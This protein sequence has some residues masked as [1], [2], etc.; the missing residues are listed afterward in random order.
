M[1]YERRFRVRAPV[2][3]VLAFHEDTAGLRALTPMPMT[4]HSAPGRLEAGEEVTFTV[5]AG[6]VPLRWEG[7]VENFSE[8]GFDDILLSGPF[9][10]WRHHHRFHRIRDNLTEVH[11]LV[12]AELPD[13]LS[14]AYPVAAL[15]W[16]SL[17]LLFSY[18]TWQTRQL[19]ES[20]WTGW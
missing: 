13:L 11:D 5:W 8:D 16:I 12:Q 9:A 3:R 15:M 17:P 7:R 14:A 10:S 19:L 1:Q 4:L 20:S 2:E 18:R 6:P